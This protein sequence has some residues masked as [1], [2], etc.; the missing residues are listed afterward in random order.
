MRFAEI[1]WT[2]F[3]LFF[4]VM[5]ACEAPGCSWERKTDIRGLT[6]HRAACH[7]FKRSSTLAS[8]KR[9]ERAKEATL[10]N[11]SLIPNPAVSASSVG[12]LSRLLQ[13]S[14]IIFLE[15]LGSPACEGPSESETHYPLQAP[16]ADVHG[17]WVI[18]S[19]CF[20][21]SRRL[22]TRP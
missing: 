1:V 20:Q 12:G 19:R 4:I 7:F 13:T 8:Q 5:V 18:P 2:G 21:L 14:N 16:Q 22:S 15:N 3:L 6:R 10:S 11:P 17:T 9:Q